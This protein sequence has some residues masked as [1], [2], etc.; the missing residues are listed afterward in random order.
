MA[1]K[2][3]RFYK[4]SCLSGSFFSRSLIDDRVSVNLPAPSEQDLAVHL[5]RRLAAELSAG[6]VRVVRR[7]DVVVTQRLIHVLEDVT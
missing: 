3:D 1:N 5:D 4:I 7:V 6:E 2:G